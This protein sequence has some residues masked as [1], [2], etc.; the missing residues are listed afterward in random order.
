MWEAAEFVYYFLGFFPRFL[1]LRV[2]AG[3]SNRPEGKMTISGAGRTS[4]L[5]PRDGLVGLLRR[6]PP[7]VDSLV[8]LWSLDLTADPPLQ[9]IDAGLE[10]GRV[11][12]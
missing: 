3:I 7:G 2:R 10:E 5:A 8:D 12:L 11:P 1:A 6:H 9:F 4:A